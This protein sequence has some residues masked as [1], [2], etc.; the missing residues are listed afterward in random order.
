M[1]RTIPGARAIVERL[2]EPEAL[3]SQAVSRALARQILDGDTENLDLF[4]G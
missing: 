1:E 2:H 4:E 3:T